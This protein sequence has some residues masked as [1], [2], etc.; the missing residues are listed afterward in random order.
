MAIRA[1]PA[2][3]AQSTSPVAADAGQLLL[4]GHGHRAPRRP[5]FGGP[6][7]PLLVPVAG[8]H[9]RTIW[10][11]CRRW[12]AA[13]ARAPSPRRHV[14]LSRRCIRPIGSRSRISPRLPV[15]IDRHGSAN[16][17]VPAIGEDAEVG[18]DDRSP[19][20][21]RRAARV[22]EH[23]H[24]EVVLRDTVAGEQGPAGRGRV[25]RNHRR[26]RL[27]RGGPHLRAHQLLHQRPG[28]THLG[29]GAAPSLA[30][31]RSTALPTARKAVRGCHWRRK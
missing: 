6:P 20:V 17:L 5:S 13:G 28:R 21:E 10:R 1:H 14:A 12:P 22:R 23:L 9:G 4:P 27:S 25:R 7:A 2:A 3:A 15:D 11:R 31:E 18:S 29:A 8:P 26:R 19:A 24:N 30:R 16:A